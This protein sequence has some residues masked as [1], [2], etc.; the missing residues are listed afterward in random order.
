MRDFQAREAYILGIGAMNTRVLRPEWHLGKT[1]ALNDE[2]VEFNHQ[3]LNS[4]RFE[5]DSLSFAKRIFA[6]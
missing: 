1:A 3:Y 2:V 5:W 6:F 4:S